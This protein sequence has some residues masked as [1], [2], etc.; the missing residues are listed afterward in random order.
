MYVLDGYFLPFGR[1]KKRCALRFVNCLTGSKT[2]MMIYASLFYLTLTSVG[3]SSVMIMR[4]FRENKANRFLGV[5]MIVLAS[6]IFVFSPGSGGA[7]VFR[8]ALLQGCGISLIFL[9][10]P[11]AFF[12][13][14]G[15][16]SGSI[17]L[18]AADSCHFALF[19]VQLVAMMPFFPSTGLSL[20]PPRINLALCI[21]HLFIYTVIIFNLIV[22]YK[23]INLL[24]FLNVKSCRLMVRWLFFFTST[25]AVLTGAIIYI[26]FSRDYLVPSGKITGSVQFVTGN[27]E[28]ALLLVVIMLAL[29]P[30]FI[31]GLSRNKGKPKGSAET[32]PKI[33]EG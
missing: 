1:L 24:K 23:K 19:A 4:S 18:S 5:C 14:R 6:I 9:V 31:Y 28:W 25:V 11:L 32:V 15:I 13:V 3:I 8:T 7:H 2:R 26:A 29:F 17:K 30:Q 12:Y 16:L 27:N 20:I 22:K 10:G 21:V 33:K